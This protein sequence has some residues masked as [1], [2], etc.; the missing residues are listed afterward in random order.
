MQDANCIF[1]RIVRGEIPSRTLYEDDE[2]L[3]FHDIN[4]LAPVHF[5]II[6]KGHIGSMMDLEDGHRDLF[7]KIMVLAPKLA[8]EQGAKDGFRLIVNTG[9]VGRQEVGHVHLHIIGGG[10]PLGAMLP[11]PRN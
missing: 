4:P 8:S 2:V 6:P 1:C 7:G 11:R 9:R 3:A 5:L 10:E